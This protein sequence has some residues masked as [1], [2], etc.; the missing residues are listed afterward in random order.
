MPMN[1]CILTAKDFTILEAMRDRCLDWEAA[2]LPI[3]RRKL[4]SAQVVFRADIPEDVATLNSRVTFRVGAG[5][6]ETRTLS[7]HAEPVPSA[8]VLPI[9]VPRGLALLGL[10]EGQAFLFNDHWGRTEKVELQKVE[11]QP[12]AARRRMDAAGPSPQDKPALVLVRNGPPDRR[13]RSGTAP[14]DFD[15][16]GPSAA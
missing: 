8:M 14:G 10:R 5:A 12:E 13:R 15:D 1:T 16:P 11:Y 9:T 2:L 3:V 4:E 7:Q 6:S